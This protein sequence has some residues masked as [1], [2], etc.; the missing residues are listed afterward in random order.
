MKRSILALLFVLII[1][2]ASLSC[3]LVNRRQ[4]GIT[5]GIPPYEQV[6]R[7]G[8]DSETEEIMEGYEFFGKVPIHPLRLA[9]S[10]AWIDTENV[11]NPSFTRL[12]PEAPLPEPELESKIVYHG[13]V[14]RKFTVSTSFLSCV[15]TQLGSEDK[16]EVV[17][18]HVFRAAGPDYNLSTVQT[19]LQDFI[20]RE[21]HPGRQF[22]Y[23]EAIRYVTLK[24]KTYTKFSAGGKAGYFV[25]ID[26]Q[27]Y[28]SD[29]R[30]RVRELVAV[31]WLRLDSD[32]KPVSGGSGGGG[33]G[34]CLFYML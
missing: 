28:R 33:G 18:E 3:A 9:G 4:G 31:D 10:I 32:A 2:A 30:F 27:Y 21:Q 20:A 7:E 17:L 34:G 12:I 8:Q 26:G 14:D 16:A 15:A 23:V 11:D 19:A 1:V 25:N 24:Y 22:F 5:S 13:L 29:D 6:N